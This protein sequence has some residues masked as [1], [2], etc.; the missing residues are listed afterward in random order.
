MILSRRIRFRVALGAGIGIP[1]L[2]GVIFASVSKD[3]QGVFQGLPDHIEGAL[4]GVTLAVNALFT[5]KLLKMVVKSRPEVGYLAPV[6]FG[7][8]AFFLIFIFSL[9]YW[10]LG[11][12]DKSCLNRRLT[13]I[14]SVYFTLTTLSTTGF[15]D[16]TPVTQ[17]CRAIVAVQIVY[18]FIVLSGFFGVFL[19]RFAP[20]SIGGG[21]AR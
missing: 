10:L 19:T 18:G 5:V 1:F 13:K 2:M 11:N 14:D 3:V 12:A 21:A 4:F 6:Y 15:G 20:S 9:Y 17:S 7:S 8:A 16:L